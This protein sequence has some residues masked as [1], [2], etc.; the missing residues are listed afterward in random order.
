MARQFRILFSG[1]FLPVFAFAVV[2]CSGPAS[3]K[4][5]SGRVAYMLRVA[6]IGKMD[7]YRSKINL[8]QGVDKAHTYISKLLFLSCAQ[9]DIDAFS[10]LVLVGAFVENPNYL[11]ALYSTM[12][13][14][15]SRGY[16][17]ANKR[18]YVEVLSNIVV[19]GEAVEFRIPDKK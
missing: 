10:A 11:D 13:I 14:A 5:A 4:S 8:E 2:S 12:H 7:T 9:D 16:P 17:V 6:D 18:Y 3:R 19:H 1:L 15:Q